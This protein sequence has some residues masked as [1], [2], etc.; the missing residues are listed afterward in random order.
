MNEI[1][2]GII[3]SECPIRVWR[4]ERVRITRR[5]D[6]Q[7]VVFEQNKGYSI[8]VVGD[9]TAPMIVVS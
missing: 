1:F 2:T 8:Y 6:K 3:A 5:F 9:T 4:I 7:F